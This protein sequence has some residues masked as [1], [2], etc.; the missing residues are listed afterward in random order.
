[1]YNNSHIQ[2]NANSYPLQLIQNLITA[3]YRIQYVYG[4]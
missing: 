3:K 4:T 1:M 2:E